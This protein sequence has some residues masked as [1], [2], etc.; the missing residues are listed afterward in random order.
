[1]LVYTSVT[2]SYLPKARVLANSVK[3]FHPDWTFVLLF[4]DE[5]PSDFNLSNEPFDDVLQMQHLPLENWRSWA[6]G[7]TVV[8][9][10][11]AVKG[12]AAE[13]LA[14]R[15]GVDKIMYLDPDI[16]VYQSLSALDEL[17][18][19]HEILLTPHL[20]VAETKY[21]AILDNEISALKHGVFNLGFFA[22][23]TSGQGLQF[24]SWWSDR[25]KVFCEDNIPAGLFTDQKWCDLAPAFFSGLLVIRD[26][27]YNVA[28][29]NIEHRP[30]SK[31]SNGVYQ[32]GNV[33]LRFYHFTSYDNGNGLGMLQKYASDQKIAQELWDEY[34]KKL[35]AA[36]QSDPKLKNWKFQEFNNGEVI[37]KE[38][39]RL[40][41]QRPDLKS[42]FTNPYHTEGK[43]FYNWWMANGKV[44][45]AKSSNSFNVI[46]DRLK[47]PNKWVH[48]FRRVTTI[49]KTEGITGLKKRVSRL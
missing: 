4:S 46:F 38:A 18:D 29:W 33:P 47:N 7:H 6:F 44:E 45:I 25:L 27:G 48:Y 26:P 28:T 22:A 36:G 3:T 19:N 39:R 37:P 2:K 31:N 23:R 10:C 32:V 11:T 21:E 41:K 17:L 24:I 30:L 1:M 43:S 12:P 8:E 40:F 14:S 35:S 34:G 9:L 5:L 13:V 49:L 42:S 15:P 20:L 16:C